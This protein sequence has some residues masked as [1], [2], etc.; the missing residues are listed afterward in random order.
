MFSL[1]HRESEAFQMGEPGACAVAFVD[2][3]QQET[4][5]TSCFCVLEL[6]GSCCWLLRTAFPLLFLI[7]PSKILKI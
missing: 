7:S 5:L 4:A 1:S 3:L 2:C 6:E